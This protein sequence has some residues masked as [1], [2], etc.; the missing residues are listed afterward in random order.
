MLTLTEARRIASDIN[1][2]DAMSFEGLRATIHEDA[3]LYVVR[4]RSVEMFDCE[5]H[6]VAETL[7]TQGDAADFLKRGLFGARY[8]S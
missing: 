8:V 5:C 7:R 2:H 1:A 4:A 3:G 6:E